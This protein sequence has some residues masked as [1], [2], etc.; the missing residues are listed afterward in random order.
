LPSWSGASPRPRR[1]PRDTRGDPRAAIAAIF[2]L[3]GLGAAAPAASPPFG[4]A[5]DAAAIERAIA[6]GRS[7]GPAERQRFHDACVIRPNDSLLDRLETGIIFEGREV[8]RVEVDFG[9]I[10]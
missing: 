9:R 8:R 6:L 10:E 1:C 2:V 7:T 3:V 5:I 4:A